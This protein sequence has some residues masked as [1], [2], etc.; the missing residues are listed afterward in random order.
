MSSHEEHIRILLRRFAD[1]KASE[2]EISEML[3]LLRTEAGDKTLE[4]F[5]MELRGEATDHLESVV[6]WEMVWNN[7]Q[8]K[9]KPAIFRKLVWTRVAAAAVIVLLLSVGG[10]FYFNK[11]QNQTAKTETLPKRFKN[12]IAPGG[13]KAILTLADGA[14]IVLDTTA[15]GIVTQQGNT[16]IIKVDSGQ[17]TYNSLNGKPGEILYNTISTPRGG[18][19][20][21]VLSDGSKVWLNAAS[22]LKY[23]TAFTGKERIVELTGEGYFEVVHNAAQPFAVS[24]NGMEVH[25]IGTAFNI[26]AY[27]DEPV[28]KT[29]LISGSVKVTDLKT[30]NSKLLEPG[31][32]AVVSLSGGEDHNSKEIIVNAAD[33]DQAIAWKNGKFQFGEGADIASI[34]RQIAR[35]YDVDVEYRGNV[36]GHIG[37]SISRNVNASK[38]FDMLEMT[39]GVKF[40][41]EG[42]KVIVM[43]SG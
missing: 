17:L 9:I 43:P 23:P 33:V 5:I 36:K 3:N 21:V 41:I 28:I 20:Q 16:K 25:D 6:N 32:Q 1:N 38:V 34:M 24:V 8:M 39:G 27:T 19:Y 15:K 35:W 26:N 13:N 10:Y 18:Q 14:Q 31:Q 4:A 30:Q 11:N 12:D 40:K 37:G 7:I 2:T 29:T 22:S 42:K